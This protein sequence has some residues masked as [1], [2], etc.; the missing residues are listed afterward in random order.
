VF[1]FLSFCSKVGGMTTVL[2]RTVTPPTG[3]DLT[4]MAAALDRAAP[5]AVEFGDGSRAELPESIAETFAHIV[6]TLMGGK[7]VTISEIGET[8]S[9]QE[10]AE[11]LQVSRPTFV[12]Y[13]ESGRLPFERPAGSHRRVKLDDVMELRDQLRQERRNI[14]AELTKEATASGP[15]ADGFVSTR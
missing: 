9:T 3:V 11:I 7:A 6:K 15:R 2:E 14:L 12:K 10:A 1:S 13:L 8:L 5:I 4:E